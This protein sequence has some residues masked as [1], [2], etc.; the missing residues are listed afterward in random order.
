MR[1]AYTAMAV[2]EGRHRFH[3]P[4][5]EDAP[6][7]S[8]IMAALADLT[9]LDHRAAFYVEGP[10]TLDRRATCILSRSVNG[11]VDQGQSA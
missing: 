2:G 11:T 9:V 10:A 3:R 6:I 4:A 1:I 5:W 8:R 7:S